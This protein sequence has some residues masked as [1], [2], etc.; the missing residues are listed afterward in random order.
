[1][2][3]MTVTAAKWGNSLAVRI[4]AS[5]AKKASIREGDEVDLTASQKGRLILRKINKEINFDHLYAQMTLDNCHSE[6]DWGV[7]VGHEDIEW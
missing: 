6:I 1:M 4:P 5:E 2:E 7:S 3:K